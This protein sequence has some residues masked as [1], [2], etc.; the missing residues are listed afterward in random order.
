MLENGWSCCWERNMSKVCK[1]ITKGKLGSFWGVIQTKKEW[2]LMGKKKH[3]G[4]KEIQNK[5]AQR[6]Q[7]TKTVFLS[8]WYVAVFGSIQ[9]GV[10]WVKQCA[11]FSRYSHPAVSI[12]DLYQFVFRS[13]FFREGGDME[14]RC[15]PGVTFLAVPIGIWQNRGWRCTLHSPWVGAA[16]WGGL[17]GMEE[18][19][20][21][22]GIETDCKMHDGKERSI[23]K[24]L[25]LAAKRLMQRWEFIERHIL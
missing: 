13:A 11:V 22:R 4:A 3:L 14:P 7:R 23:M 10:W 25:F 19:W 6:M 9:Q 15:A 5:A 17:K 24:V 21:F 16:M 2:L 18:D 12:C 20:N 1:W 8:C